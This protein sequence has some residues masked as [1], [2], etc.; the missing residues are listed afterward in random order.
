MMRELRQFWSINSY[1][2]R[3]KRVVLLNKKTG[4]K[5]S[6]SRL[7]AMQMRCLPRD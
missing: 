4:L 1:G 3:G 6:P 7:F 2:Y 5:A